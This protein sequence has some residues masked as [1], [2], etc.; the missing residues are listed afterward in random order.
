MEQLALEI[1]VGQTASREIN[2][3]EEMVRTYAQITGDYNPLHFA[4]CYLGCQF[5]SPISNLREDEYG[6]PLENRCRFPLEIVRAVR[7]EI[8]DSM[9]LMVRI[10][11]TEY[12]E[13]GWSLDDSV[14]FARRLK[15]EGVDLIDCSSGGNTPDRPMNP[16]PG[17]Q[18]P[19]SSRIK[20]EAD[21]LTGA[22]GLITS[23]DQAENV[24]QENH[25]DVV[26]IGRELLRNP[27]WPLYAE[28]EL[29]GYSAWPNQYLT[30]E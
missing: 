24:L 28:Y 9:P 4:H 29:D 7:R 23:P 13:G 26:L 14:R 18:V 3:T 25:A 1:I 11:A 12:I 20:K 10:S 19:Y 6:G 27:Y 22:V 17:Y 16:Y 8:L 30:A 21:I 2:V 5:L 15:K